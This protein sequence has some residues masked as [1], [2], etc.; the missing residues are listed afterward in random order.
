MSELCND[1]VGMLLECLIH[2]Y[3]L[4]FTGS[5]CCRFSY[6]NYISI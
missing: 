6:Y 3:T 4:C 5:P 1:L 2:D